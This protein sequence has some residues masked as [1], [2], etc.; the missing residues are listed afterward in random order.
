VASANKS[1]GKVKGKKAGKT[2]IKCCLNYGGD[3]FKD[4]KSLTVK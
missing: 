4:S 3:K 1:S 2:S